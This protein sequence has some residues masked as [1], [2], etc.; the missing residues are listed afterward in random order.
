MKCTGKVG[1]EKIR[2][3]KKN[4]KKKYFKKEGK[5]AERDEEVRECWKKVRENEEGGRNGD[6]EKN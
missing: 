6:F 4:I 1:K 3:K 5:K 2:Y